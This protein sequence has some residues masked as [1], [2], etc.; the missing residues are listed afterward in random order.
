MT[1]LAEALTKMEGDIHL[2][3]AEIRQIQADLKAA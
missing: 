2:A 1:S 3:A